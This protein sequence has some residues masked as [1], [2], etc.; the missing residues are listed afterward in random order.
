[1][2]DLLTVINKVLEQN[3]KPLIVSLHNHTNLRDDLEF[4]SFMLAQLTVEVEEYTGVDIFKDSLVY[5]V[6]DILAK[7]P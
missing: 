2:N 6:S 3:D 4:D 7:L 5:T 1:M